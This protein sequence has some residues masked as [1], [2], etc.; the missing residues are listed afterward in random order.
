MLDALPG[1]VPDSLAVAAAVAL[2]IVIVGGLALVIY[3]VLFRSR[4]EE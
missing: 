1:E 2:A 4:D 3:L